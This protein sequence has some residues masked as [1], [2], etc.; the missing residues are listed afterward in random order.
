MLSWSKKKNR[1]TI[2]LSKEIKSLSQALQDSVLGRITEIIEVFFS[3]NIVPD[4]SSLE[5]ALLFCAKS[6]QLREALIILKLWTVTTCG[7]EVP[8]AANIL[9]NCGAKIEPYERHTICRGSLSFCTRFDSDVAKL[10]YQRHAAMNLSEFLADAQNSFEKLCGVTRI[11]DQ[12]WQ[13]R[14]E[15]VALSKGKAT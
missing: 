8:S 6:G 13:N 11:F 7:I 14:T 3:E 12:Q 15:F 9:G 4:S 5:A 10:Y 1:A 2:K